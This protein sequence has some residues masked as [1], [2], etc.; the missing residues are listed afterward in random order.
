MG[1]VL[2]SQLRVADP[3]LAGAWK[4][5][6]RLWWQAA[7]LQ[8]GNC[9]QA[10]YITRTIGVTYSRVSAYL[11]T[12]PSVESAWV[13]GDSPVPRGRSTLAPAGMN[14]AV[15]DDPSPHSRPR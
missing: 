14:Q 4:E 8:S 10:A 15:E 9:S 11:N 1:G 13:Q 7:R 12:M 2:Q 6:A 5:G 3:R